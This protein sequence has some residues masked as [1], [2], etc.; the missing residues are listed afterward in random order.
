MGKLYEEDYQKLFRELHSMLNPEQ[1]AKLGEVLEAVR[2][3][4]E[5]NIT[6]YSGRWLITLKEALVFALAS[7]GVQ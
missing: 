5:E 4:C 6:Y 7:G 1:L 2:D 3:N